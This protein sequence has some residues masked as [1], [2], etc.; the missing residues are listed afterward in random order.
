VAGA[1]ALVVAVLSVQPVANLLSSRQRMNAS[2]DPLH[3]VNTY[4]AFGRVHRV[5]DEIVIQGTRDEAPSDDARWEEYEL[6]CK[7]GD[8]I[9]RPCLVTPYH[10]RLDWQ[11]WFAALSSYDRS[12]WLA[13]LVDKLVAGDPSVR[14]LI[15]SDPFERSGPPR[16]V[17]LELYRYELTRFG[18]GPAWWRRHRLGEYMRP[19]SRDDPAPRRPSPEQARP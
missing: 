6:P 18:D 1:Y 14:P 19:V 17:R 5:R 7:P 4:G 16:F 8:P 3:L 13:A 10:H 9:R 2:F 12:P 11:M 15:A